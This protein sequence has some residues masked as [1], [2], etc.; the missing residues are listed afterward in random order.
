MHRMESSNKLAGLTLLLVLM[1]FQ[2]GE[3]APPNEDNCRC[4]TLDHIWC[5][6]FGCSAYNNPRCNSNTIS[7]LE[8]AFIYTDGSTFNVYYGCNCPGYTYNNGTDIGDNGLVISG[9]TFTGYNYT[10]CNSFAHGDGGG[11]AGCCAYCC[12]PSPTSTT[13]TNSSSDPNPDG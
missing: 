6:T 10:D 1:M 11:I 12:G 7:I 9:T 4:R 13:T 5:C 3:G 2:S 8:P